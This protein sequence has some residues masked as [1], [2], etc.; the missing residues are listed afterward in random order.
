ML[1]HQVEECDDDSI[2]M[3]TRLVVVV[4][5]LVTVLSVIFAKEVVVLLT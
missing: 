3:M 4:V 2:R 1:K 5:K